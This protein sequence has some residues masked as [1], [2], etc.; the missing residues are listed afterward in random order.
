MKV[1]KQAVL[2][3]TLATGNSWSD[4]YDKL[5]EAVKS[6]LEM[7]SGELWLIHALANKIVNNGTSLLEL[8]ANKD[9]IKAVF[10]E[11][12]RKKAG[13]FFT[14]I[15]WAE[16]AHKY[17]AKYIPDW[18]DYNIWEGSCYSMDT[19][20]YIRIKSINVSSK[21]L[22]KIS[23]IEIIDE[24]TYGWV[25]YHTFD[26]KTMEVLGYDK[27]NDYV[28]WTKVIRKFTKY[29]DSYMY[30]FKG[31]YSVGG[32][33]YTA[34]IFT[35]ANVTEDHL[36]WYLLNGELK[37]SPASDLFKI[38]QDA[39]Y[40]DSK[41]VYEVYAYDKDID[42]YNKELG[43]RKIRLSYA[44]A[45]RTKVE[46]DVWDIEM[47]KHHIFLTRISEKMTMFSSN[48]GSGNLVKTANH[49]TD[50]LF[51]ST[52]QA[53]DVTMLQATPE[54]QGA[55]IFQCDFLADLDYDSYNTDFLN[56]L[57]PRLKEII[58]NDE[59]LIIFMNPPYKSGSAKNTDVGSYMVDIGLGRAAYDI[60]YQFCYRVMHLVE[61]FNLTNCYYGFFG[62][63]TFFTG[64]GANLLLKEF[65]HCF[66]F[67]D[68]MCISAQEFSDTSESIL[69]GIGFTLWK[70]RGGYIG[71]PSEDYHKDILLEKKYLEPDGTVGCEG[72]ILYEPPR[73]KLSDWVVPKDV[74]FYNQAPLMTSH[75]TFKGREVFEKVA[76]KSG[77]LA[78]NALGTLMVGNT[79]TRSADQSAV[80]SMPTTIQYVDIT[81]ENFWRCVSSYAFR[82]VIDAGWAIAKKE[83]SAPNENVEG[84]W[85]WV[86]N[87]LVIFLF[88]YK[89]MMSS[90]RNV[91]W[92]G[93]LYTIRNHLFYLSEE[94]VR[95]HCHDEV[96]LRDLEANPP[97]NQYML[98]MIAESQ[99]WWAPEIKQLFDW[100]KK[101]TLESYDRR[102]D[103]GY[104]GSLEC[105]DAGFQQLRSGIEESA[106]FADDLTKLVTQARDYMRKDLDKF[107]FISEVTDYEDI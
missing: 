103:F 54:F 31:A 84:Y 4:F 77:K 97:T 21:L 30:S 58:L 7:Q 64:A 5:D 19:E 51:M 102:K 52:L 68:G 98:Q 29:C 41:D 2:Y 74:A 43:L 61:M 92:N 83:I 85:V 76:P 47:E 23:N 75:L 71:S 11:E 24:Y 60:F 45:E 73:E 63:L 93:E 89:S 65:E 38:L 1:A 32:S 67:L 39:F 66:E 46:C 104:K 96:I 3:Y 90:L 56:K 101:Y 79:L 26:C 33:G 17:L 72:R 55:H 91:E 8:K 16:D 9:A 12:G 94:E 50:K 95:A 25:D 27:E 35:G 57:D 62:P 86:R 105:W 107:G 22:E 36:M 6:P 106:Q 37:S 34:T 78:S 40:S 18:H 20:I 82:R 49:P 14:P 80:L 88:E 100:C 99:Q 42:N 87:A 28:E 10:D 70:S 69:W 44:N 59:K 53:D 15:V 48:C 13:E 81:L